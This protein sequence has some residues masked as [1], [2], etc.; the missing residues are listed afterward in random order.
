M[1]T[2]IK[3]FNTLICLLS[4]WIQM[5]IIQDYTVGPTAKEVYKGTTKK[6]YLKDSFNQL[7]PFNWGL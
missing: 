3:W 2:A 5:P 6:M 7:L 1:E 4:F